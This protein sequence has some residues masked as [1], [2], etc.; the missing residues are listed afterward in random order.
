MP[1]DTR[2]ALR[3]ER[4]EAR[5][6]ADLKQLL[7]RAAALRGSTLSEF[8]VS[9]AREAAERAIREHEIITLSVRDGEAFVQAL[10][11]PPEPNEAL[12]AAARRHRGL[13]GSK[14]S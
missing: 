14:G 10:L 13:L 5:V 9:S 4:L 12:R 11:N 2:P 7:Q 6:R 1:T 8:L 3:S